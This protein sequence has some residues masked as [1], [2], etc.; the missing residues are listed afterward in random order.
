[1]LAAAWKA[2]T[3]LLERVGQQ[4]PTGKQ[5]PPDKSIAGVAPG[6]PAIQI[7]RDAMQI[8]AIDPGPVRSAWIA[9]DGNDGNIWGFG[10]ED[11]GKIIGETLPQELACFPPD[12][13]ALQLVI[14]MIEGRG[15]PVGASVFETCVWIG[16]LYQRWLEITDD[17]SEEYTTPNRILRR[18]IKLHLCGSA[19]AKDSNVRQALIDK[20]GGS[21]ETAIGKKANPGPLYGIKK[22]IWAALAVAVTWA[23]TKGEQDA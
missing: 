17:V 11:N 23:E 13:F 20:F 21:K 2:D 12:R 8:L 9:Y 22:D 7:E 1:M 19:R 3:C 18:T 16:R 15:M 10:L 4:T 6:P 14:E 5:K